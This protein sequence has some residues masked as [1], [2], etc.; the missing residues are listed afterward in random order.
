MFPTRKIL[1]AEGLDGQAPELLVNCRVAI[2][3][4]V[5]LA[6]FLLAVE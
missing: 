6:A 2:D 4:V 3:L 5:F 1:F